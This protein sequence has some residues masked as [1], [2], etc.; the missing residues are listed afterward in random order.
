MTD[1]TNLKKALLTLKQSYKDYS[2]CSISEFYFDYIQDSCVQR[3]EYTIEM[4]WKLAKRILKE[5][6]AKQ[7]K[8]L[9][10]NNIFRYMES[11]GFAK[12]WENWKNYYKERNN[13]SHEYD[14][15][16]SRELI[17]IIPDFI[18]D[19]EYFIEKFD[20]AKDD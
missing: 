18:E 6:Y 4:A 8:E 1:I 20:E 3:F 14:I 13:T 12:N 17:K 7:E 16:K 9:T 15:E 11:Y 5:K 10:V 2:N 19:V